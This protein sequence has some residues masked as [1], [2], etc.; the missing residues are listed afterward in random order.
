MWITIVITGPEKLDI[1]SYS[2]FS[3]PQNKYNNAYII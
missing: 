1:F 3:F 2:Q